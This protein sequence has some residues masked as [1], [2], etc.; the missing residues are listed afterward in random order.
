MQLLVLLL[1][2]FGIDIT[3]FESRDCNSKASFAVF[4]KAIFVRTS[5]ISLSGRVGN[6]VAII[7]S[8][9]SSWQSPNSI[10][11]IAN[12]YGIEIETEEDLVNFNISE[13]NNSEPPQETGKVLKQ[14]ERDGTDSHQPKSE[15]GSFSQQL[16]R[17]KSLQLVYKDT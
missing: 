8:T 12:A 7:Q 6:V 4:P 17:R 1:I 14:F 16:L 5:S 10:S 3:S 15:C 13:L 11:I 2:D 9:S